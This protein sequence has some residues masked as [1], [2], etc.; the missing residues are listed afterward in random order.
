MQIIMRFVFKNAFS[1]SEELTRY[2]FV[3]QIWLGASLALRENVHIR[4]EII[5]RL[6]KGKWVYLA[7]I[8]SSL[9]WALF[10]FFIVY[11]SLGWI[12]TV[13]TNHTVSPA[14]RIPMGYV[15]MSVPFG[16]LAMGIR[17]IPI[18]YK[19]IRLLLGLDKPADPEPENALPQEQILSGEVQ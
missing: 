8:I 1:W 15:Y 10:C 5:F 11:T 18:L 17:L 13:L 16:C 6:L 3:G 19:N 12:S 7:E 2:I 9:I 4:V 14:M